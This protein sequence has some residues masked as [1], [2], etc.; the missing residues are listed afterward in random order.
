MLA[1]TG[2]DARDP[3]GIYGDLGLSSAVS[4]ATLGLPAYVTVMRSR[5]LSREELLGALTVQVVV[6]AT[7][8]RDEWDDD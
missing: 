6:L 2:L 5:R 3:G 7:E 8:L 4:L 1:G